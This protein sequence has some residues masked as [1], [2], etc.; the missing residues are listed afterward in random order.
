M[1]SATIN[2]DKMIFTATVIRQI[3]NLSKNGH[4]IG[5]F[6]NWYIGIGEGNEVGTD[7][8]VA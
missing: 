8:G 6:M 7:I 4:D 1:T 3:M 2:N 5:R